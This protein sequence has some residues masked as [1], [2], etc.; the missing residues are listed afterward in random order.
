M[1]TIRS[2]G[3][4]AGADAGRGPYQRCRWCG[5]PEDHAFLNLDPPQRR[6]RT[7]EALTLLRESQV[8]PLLLVFEDLHWIDT[9]TQALLD[10][11]VESLPTARSAGQLPARVPARLGQQ[12]VTANCDWTRSRRR[13]PRTSC[14]PSGN[15]P[16]LAPL[17]QLL[18]AAPRASSS[19]RRACLGRDRGVGGRLWGVPSE[20]DAAHHS[21]TSHRAGCAGRPMTGCRPRRSASSRRRGRDWH[22]G[23][24]AA[25]PGHRRPACGSPAQRPGG[26]PGRRAAPLQGCRRWPAVVA[27]GTSVPITAAVWRRPGLLLGRQPVDTCRQHGL[28]G[29][30]HLNGRQRLGQT[31]RPTVRPPAPRSPPGAHTLLQGRRDCPCA[32]N[33]ELCEGSQPGIVPQ[34]GL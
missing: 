1:S 4:G 18:I 26:A 27:K 11:L 19:W 29:G 12:D 3:D 2:Q 28:H 6:R 10:S 30:R 7:L 8:Q 14:R 13:V 9:E 32:G 21:S 24:R 16:K 25:A 15:H 23:A 34:E 31:I 33:Q 17:T 22:G 5:G 20:A